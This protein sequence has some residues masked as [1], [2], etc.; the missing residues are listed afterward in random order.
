M[1]SP[2][3]RPIMACRLLY[4]LEEAGSVGLPLDQ[5]SLYPPLGRYSITNPPKEAPSL[6]ASVAVPLL[7]QLL[8]SLGPDK[9][10]SLATYPSGAAPLIEKSPVD[11]TFTIVFG[12]F[13]EE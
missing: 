11:W 8:T 12:S 4:I 9:S 1:L 3:T 6:T 2:V 5:Y 10:S 7:T 13:S